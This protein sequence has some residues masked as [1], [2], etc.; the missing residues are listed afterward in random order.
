MTKYIL[1]CLVVAVLLCCGRELASQPVAKGSVVQRSA[2]GLDLLIYLP[3]GY[4]NT[5]SYKT[6]YV[7]DG[8]TI[9]GEQGL[10]MDAIADEMIARKMIGPLIMVAIK[11]NKDRSS[12][13]LPYEDAGARQDFGDYTPR[14][15]TYTKKLVEKI[16]PFIE[17]NFSAGK[18][19]GIAG[20]SFG[21]LH[22]VWSALNHPTVFKFAAGLSPSYWVQDFKL[23]TEASKARDDQVYY[24]DVGTGEWNYYVPFISHTNQRLLENIFYYEVKDA[25]HTLASWRK[26]VPNILLLFAGE[27]DR[28]QYTWEIQQEIIKSA[29]TGKYYLRINPVITYTSGLTCSLSYAAKFT[30][31]NPADGIVNADGSFRFLQPNDLKVSVSYNGEEKKLILGYDEIEKIKARL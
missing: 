12:H 10:N 29:Y 4:D 1:H 18:T 2:S 24:F 13:Y 7:N 11:S 25:N 21:G 14:A 8:Q 19:R 26:R 9:F 22:A 16:V 15:H 20:Y 6:L 3:P 31:E 17:K 27:T 5:Q 23:F 28:S 30:V